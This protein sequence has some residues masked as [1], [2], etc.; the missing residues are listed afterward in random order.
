M[1]N[2]APMNG[3]VQSSD[4]NPLRA[5]AN[6][7]TAL[8]AAE[9]GETKTAF[10]R[11][12]LRAGT[13][14]NTPDMRALLA[15][16]LSEAWISP[17][18]LFNATAILIKAGPAR[19][20]MER[21]V[22][23]WPKPVSM[24]EFA[25]AA[26]LVGLYDDALLRAALQ[27][28]FVSD[29]DLEKFLTTIRRAILEQS[30][31]LD[32]SK[33]PPDD[34]LTFASAL[35]Q[36]CSINEYVWRAEREEKASFDRLLRLLKA[37]QKQALAPLWIAVAASYQPLDEISPPVAREGW[38]AA[39]QTLIKQQI[40]EPETVDSFRETIPRLTGINDRVSVAVRE[41]YE[42]NPYPRWTQVP[43]RAGQRDII[44]ELRAKFPHADIQSEDNGG[45]FNVLIAGCGTGQQVPEYSA[46]PRAR[47]L[48]IDLSLASL[49]Y[50]KSKAIELGLQNVEFAQA[51]ILKLNLP[52][53]SFDL[54]VSTG[55]L[56]HMENPEAG[57]RKLVSLLRPSGL[58]AIGLYSELAR[59]DIVAARNVIA[60][61]NYRSTASAIRKFRQEIIGGADPK[62][63]SILQAPDFYSLSECRDLLF[64]VHEQRFTL[65]RIANFLSANGLSFLGFES[66]INVGPDFAKLFSEP[67]HYADLT[68]WHEF[69]QKN[70]DTFASM[71][72][73]WV[74][75]RGA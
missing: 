22:W 38:P 64:H 2:S 4:N 74:Q 13:I 7:T 15:R 9:T 54:I 3:P 63:K 31:R 60:A 43:S 36:Q 14:S 51:D 69:E 58:M 10:A 71:Y 41:Q 53:A 44:S 47:T 39:V 24:E 19:P 32:P 45:A 20:F 42:E 11:A 6:A 40:V 68:R 8:K 5:L 49:A 21:A 50:A 62:L 65:P 28:S 33:P 61:K 30:L 55:V 73:F 27:S 18:L 70:P 25:L 12:L 34:L 16:V 72:N 23:A 26:P 57:W 1:A 37:S 29:L 46:Y 59:R 48:A 67:G 66:T 17:R 52:E 75:K 56:H 35:A